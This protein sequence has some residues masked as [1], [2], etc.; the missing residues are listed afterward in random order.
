MNNKWHCL[1]V[2]QIFPESREQIELPEDSI[3]EDHETLKILKHTHIKIKGFTYHENLININI[4][5]C[6]LWGFNFKTQL[7]LLNFLS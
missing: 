2:T 3:F 1:T 6:F 7:K 5:S 4:L